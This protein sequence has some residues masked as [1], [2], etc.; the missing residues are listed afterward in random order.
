MAAGRRQRIALSVVAAV[1]ASFV[2]LAVPA[3]ADEVAQPQAAIGEVGKRDAQGVYSTQML[4]WSLAPLANDGHSLTDYDK[5]YRVAYTGDQVTTTNGN[6][7]GN[8]PKHIAQ[9]DDLF[10]EPGNNNGTIQ[11]EVDFKKPVAF[12]RVVYGSR[13]DASLKGFANEFEL[14]TTNAPSGTSEADA[15]WKLVARGTGS[16]TSSLCIFDACPDGESVSATRVRFRY[17]TSNGNWPSCR[18]LRFYTGDPHE[19]DLDAVW[20]NYSHTKIADGFDRATA[21]ALI[22]GLKRSPSYEVVYGPDVERLQRILDGDASYDPRLEVSNEATTPAESRSSRA[23]TRVGDVASYARNTL[24][25]SNGA[26]NRQVTGVWYPSGET[27]HIW[28]HRESADDPL[29]KVHW[30]QP[31]GYWAS[32]RSSA[33]QLAEG[34]NVLTVPTFRNVD[35]KT[36]DIVAGC[37]AYLENP[38]TEREQDGLVEVYFEGGRTYPVYR[39]GD[40]IAPYMEE[41]RA[42]ADRVREDPEGEMDVTELVSGHVMMTVQA[43]RADE[44]YG[45]RGHDAQ[46]ALECWDETIH[47]CL[48]FEGISFTPGV[49]NYDPRND[50]LNENFRVSQV[51]DLGWMFTAGEHIGVYDDPSAQDVLI[52]PLDAYGESRIAPNWGLIHEWGHSIDI[53]ARTIQETTNNMPAYFESTFCPEF[54]RNTEDI[55]R[56]NRMAA[57][58]Y[59]T[60]TMFAENRYNFMPFWLVEA[61][62]P[63]WWGSVENLYRYTPA[64]EDHGYVGG[65]DT[66]AKTERFVLNASLA[67]RYDLRYWYERWGLNMDEKEAPFTSAGAS[68]AFKALFEAKLASGEISHVPQGFEGDVASKAIAANADGT[69]ELPL[70]YLDRGEYSAVKANGLDGLHIYHGDEAP[71]IA[72]VF[73]GTR[74][75][76]GEGGGTSTVAA[77]TVVI[78]KSADPAH[79]VYLVEGR[80]TGSAGD[81]GWEYLGYAFGGTFTDE[82]GPVGGQPIEYRVRALDRSLHASGYSE[83]K[84]AGE[85]TV[86]ARYVTDPGNAAALSEPSGAQEFKSLQEAVEKAHD[87]TVIE[88]LGDCSGDGIRVE[89]SITLR[90]HAEGTVTVSRSGAQ[91]IFEL[92]GRVGDGG[93]TVY[94]TLTIETS[95]ENPEAA[96][97]FD[98][99]DASGTGPGIRVTGGSKLVATGA[100]F[101]NFVNAADG[102]P[103]QGGAVN[104]ADSAGRATIANCTFSGNRAL[105][106]GAIAGRGTLA[107]SDCSFS[108]NTATDEGG[109]IR[110]YSGGVF[111]LKR[112]DF[113]GNT[114]VRGGAI[115]LEGFT[116]VLGCSIT[117]NAAKFGGGIDA[118]LG[119]RQMTIDDAKAD[120]DGA[121]RRAVIEG[122]RASAAGDALYVANGANSLIYLGDCD[123][124][125]AGDGRAAI[126]L[127]EGLLH[128]N[129]DL[130]DCR[131]NVRRIATTFST[132]AGGTAV[133]GALSVAGASTVTV[134]DEWPAPLAVEVVE[135][136]RPEPVLAIEGF[137]ASAFSEHVSLVQSG[138]G[139]AL[140]WAPQGAAEGAPATAGNIIV[141]KGGDVRLEANGGT[142]VGAT[143]TSYVRGAVTYLP[144]NVAKAGEVFVGWF[145]DPALTGS[146]VK[147]IPADAEGEQVFYAKWASG[148]YW[149]NYRPNGGTLPAGVQ[150]HRA[151]T[152]RVALAT[153]VRNG[154]TFEGWYEK[155]DFSGEPIAVIEAGTHEGTTTL[156]AKWSH[157]A[158][159]GEVLEEQAATC[160]TPGYRLIGYKCV[161]CK[162]EL[163]TVRE[164][165][166]ATGHDFGEWEP[167]SGAEAPENADGTAPCFDADAQRRTCKTCGLVELKGVDEANH[168]WRSWETVEGREASCTEDGLESRTCDAC[169]LQE[170]RSVPAT[171]HIVDVPVE[172]NGAVPDGAQASP[173]MGFGEEP[174]FDG[175]MAPGG[176][177]DGQG[178]EGELEVVVKDPTC[179]RPGHEVVYGTCSACGERF[180]VSYEQLMPLGH[181]FAEDGT[182][183]VCGAAKAEE[184]ESGGNGSAGGPTSDGAAE[185]D[186][187]AGDEGT[188]PPAADDGALD[189][190]DAPG[191]GDAADGD[192]TQSEPGTADGGEEGTGPGTGEGA[193]GSNG[194]GAAGEGSSSA[195]ADGGTGED[196][197]HADSREHTDGTTAPVT[198]GD[199]AP[200]GESATQAPKIA[201]PQT[202][203]DTPWLPSILGLLGAG[204]GCFIV[205]LLIVRKEFYR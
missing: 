182:C 57:P 50:Y 2:A 185:D 109:A 16:T 195:D 56:A 27:V 120:G 49:G 35:Y 7:P 190:S 171:G 65:K 5:A 64:D 103:G 24:K 180:L 175:Q 149:I 95:P 22:D 102:N 170:F 98:G 155:S 131:D 80:P 165:I 55:Q 52:D 179:D 8:L 88:L 58:G 163:E 143:V 86:V 178:D 1:L 101:E 142:V 119:N 31:Y 197:P 168:S 81:E 83:A 47:R 36:Y 140:E 82:R 164:E 17:V 158:D 33:I 124:E 13:L 19:H 188:V 114:G 99:I 38:Y 133:T 118:R 60:G 104:V 169:G 40:P 203:D 70:W 129:A 78:E 106:G 11:I 135:L 39:K 46:Q 44:M 75:V 29:P 198:G 43:T 192:G 194:G 146:S 196:V 9:D 42:Q 191:T 71:A 127:D 90:P 110:N 28:V 66:L 85:A 145:R 187:G 72:R 193:T 130:E 167:L 15:H 123:L 30:A 162:I 79:L 76:A 159:K 68:D 126:R 77:N 45:A 137:D 32:W 184:D 174:S 63:G 59:A 97:V 181:S 166:A 21:Q 84:S 157:G 122:N 156:Y 152:D 96:I 6:Y 183:V 121:S 136:G 134:H 151:I 23:L 161:D 148:K 199:A 111:E 160:T 138:E 53:P 107:I 41:L 147:S 201:V 128:L 89:R 48:E 132:D 74:A 34:E 112:C 26:T 172:G 186:P 4:P 139:A 173:G 69:Y 115:S 100:T 61:Y 12:Q 73:S 54:V 105:D 93:A 108:G 3:H 94:P 20:G 18:A 51:W 117:A 91:P 144:T 141:A 113:T 10:W 205:G 204:I 92:A 200:Q 153:P 176:A 116:Q 189:G 25:F 37:A 202:G 177:D 62:W 67:A 154:F 125:A 150:T 14:Y 87:G